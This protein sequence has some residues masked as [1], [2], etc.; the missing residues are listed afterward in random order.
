MTF[1][2][3]VVID[4]VGILMPMPDSFK[5]LLGNAIQ[6]NVFGFLVV[7]I[8]APILEE[9]LFRGIILEGFLK[10]YT[11]WKAILWSALLFGVSHLNPWQAIPGIGAGILIGWIYWKTRSILPGILIHFTNNLTGFLMM[12]YASTEDDSLYQYFDNKTLYFALFAASLGIIYLGYK[13]VSNKPLV[14]IT[15]IA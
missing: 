6:L 5:E 4:P 3:M 2:F 10:N 12:V 9:I 15:P 13:I 11:P 8:A 7:A 1:A 14:A